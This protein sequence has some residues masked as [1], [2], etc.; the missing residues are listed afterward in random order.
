MR[1]CWIEF[2]EDGA[3]VHTEVQRTVIKSCRRF[4]YEEVDVFIGDPDTEEIVMTPSVRSLLGR[5]QRLASILR[6]RRLTRGAL[7]LNMPEVKIDL[8]R[9]GRVAGAHVVENTESHQI[10]EEFMLAANE[11]VAKK[12]LLQKE[13]FCGEFTRHRTYGNSG[14]LQNLFSSLVLR[15]SHLKAVLNCNVCL[16]LPV[17]NQSACSP[18]RSFKKSFAS[19]VCPSRPGALC[20]P[21]I[22]IVTL[23]LRF[24]DILT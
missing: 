21:V 19:S 15:S 6:D 7:E 12:L 11:A 9:S 18:L 14:S 10:V 20:W 16:D 17:T 3:P 2:S 4:T 23:H 1:T 24:V 8:D 5:M 13:S 22:V